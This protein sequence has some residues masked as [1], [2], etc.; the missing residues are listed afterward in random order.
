MFNEKEGW[1]ADGQPERHAANRV[2]PKGPF[3][4]ERL[5]EWCQMAKELMLQ[6]D[7]EDLL[8]RPLYEYPPGNG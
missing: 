7:T 6:H 1:K 3:M 2:V 4:E 5:S 8:V